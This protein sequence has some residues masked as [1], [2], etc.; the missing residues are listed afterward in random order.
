MN[1]S[2]LQR[3][4]QRI[5]KYLKNRNVN[6]IITRDPTVIAITNVVKK[7]GFR[8]QKLA[9]QPKGM[10]DEKEVILQAREDEKTLLSLSYYSNSLLQ[11]FIMDVCI[12]YILQR[13]FLLEP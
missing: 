1:F 6:A 8:T 12:A 5:F 9:V 2:S 13:R 4:C 10:S 7:L 3:A 11:S